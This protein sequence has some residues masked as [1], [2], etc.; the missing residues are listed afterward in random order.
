MSR[1]ALSGAA[2]YE[3]LMQIRRPSLWV[4]TLFFSPILF[5]FTRATLDRPCFPTIEGCFHF[6]PIEAV[7]YWAI[8]SN[9]IV[10]IAVGLLM[11]DRFPRDFRVKMDDA[12][13]AIPGTAATRVFAKYLGTVGAT[14]IP[15]FILYAVGLGVILSRGYGPSVIP[16]GVAAFLVIN[17]PAMLFVG[18][19]SI[20]CTGFMWTPLFQFL[21]VGYWLWGTLNPTESIPTLSG[22]LLSSGGVFAFTGILRA[23]GYHDYVPHPSLALALANIAVILGLGALALVAAW[24]LQLAREGR[25]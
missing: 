8:I 7:A 19:F 6:A 9:L 16:L 24:R 15:I 17:V 21:F 25:Q 3:F 5:T 13:Q 10:S 1:Q 22:T 14:I 18:A 4:G 23:R 20:A 11:A 2:R 12:L